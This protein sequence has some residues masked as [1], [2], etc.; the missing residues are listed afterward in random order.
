MQTPHITIEQASVLYTN[1]EAML[2]LS[3][4]LIDKHNA[5][6][7][8]TN[9]QPEP[10]EPHAALKAMYKQQVKD[11]TLDNYVWEYKFH[12]SKEFVPLDGSVVVLGQ[13]LTYADHEYRCTP[14]PTCQVR[15]LETDE[16]KTITREAAKKLKAE[17]GAVVEWAT[18]LGRPLV[19]DFILEGIYTYKLKVKPLKQASWK[20]VPTGVA[21]RDKKTNVVWLH[22]GAGDDTQALVT[23]PQNMPF[24]MRWIDLGDFELAPASEQPWIPVIAPPEGLTV[25]YSRF[26]ECLRITGLAERWVLK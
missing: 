1:A 25:E 24:G 4:Q 14:K 2:K 15:N 11:G 10:V 20:D 22:Q 7:E 19:N 23:A 17:L 5:R 18:P 8:Q 21:V 13:L 3:N 9:E 26:H 16:L 12:L 6:E